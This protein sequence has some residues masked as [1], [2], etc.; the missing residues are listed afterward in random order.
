M[1]HLLSNPLSRIRRRRRRGFTL[2]E[3]AMTTAIIGFGVVGMV[4]LLAAGTVSNAEGT[5]LTTAV[6]LANNVREI[7]LGMAYNDPEQP[8][9]WAT[10]E[11]T[12]NPNTDVV[13]YDDVFD[14]D[15]VTFSPPL[16]VRRLPIGTYTNWAQQV[17]V[18]TVAVDQLSSVRPKDVTERT[19]RVTVTVT[20]NGTPVHT[21]SWLVVA[22]NTN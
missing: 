3:A 18:E 4:Q 10:K 22:P 9:V 11:G 1:R 8:T 13:L 5:E 2:I 7:S 20:R 16:D 19:A 17:V 15:G 14:L 21:A 6:N 12:G